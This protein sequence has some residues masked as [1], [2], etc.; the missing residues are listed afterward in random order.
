MGAEFLPDL[1]VIVGIGVV[2][3]L[4]LRKAGLPSI[5]GFIF[6]GALVGPNALGFVKDAHRV[7][8]VAELG[9]VLLLFGVGLELSFDRVRR[10]WRA[11]AFGGTLQV[12][13]TI[14]LAAGLARLGGVEMRPALF[15]GCFAAASSTA[16]VLRGLAARGEID[17]PYGRLTVGILIFQD[18]CV[19]PMML[20]LPVF[21]GAEASFWAVLKPI[22]VAALVLA[23]ILV[24]ARLV[25]PRILEV[26]ARTRQRDLFVLAVLL[27]CLGTA[28]ATTSA[29]LSLALGAF[30]GGLVVA[31]SEY[32]HQAL[33]DVIP[34]RELFASLFFV[35]VGMLLDPHR[36][37]ARPDA[38]LL[39]LVA[40][41]VGKFLAVLETAILLRLG[42]RT[43]VRSGAALAHVGEFSFVLAREAK[44]TGILAGD[45]GADLLSASALSML[46]A[47]LLMAA[48][49]R[50]AAGAGRIRWL[51]RLLEVRPAADASAAEK[52]ESH[53][54][55]AGYG[56]AGEE[57]CQALKTCGVPY[58]IVD[59]NP[60]NVHRAASRGEPAFF[61]DV[62]GPEILEA[63]GAHR[64]R[65]LVVLINDPTAAERAVKAA[66][67]LAPSLHIVVRS[68]YVG[69]IAPLLAAGASHVVPAELEAAVEVVAQVLARHGAG[70]SRLGAE[71]ARI[72]GRREEN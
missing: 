1:L 47:P 46:F 21:A 16:I 42:L 20:L 54:I 67:T 49:P 12:G 17:S 50:L 28:W 19:I 58:V 14:L 72:R 15:L 13:L 2:V 51:T 35:S 29:G 53:V 24:A 8:A 32:R 55:V 7:E 43:A 39:L 6:A 33:S 60:Q 56:V 36:L 65:E 11:V 62:T 71:I 18:L 48:G 66:R 9:V 45:L 4:L 63:V 59:L 30:L 31:G 10:L 34:F 37:L 41:L 25:V 26:V 69:D 23:G 44:G 61:G 64:A 70:A 22:G 57:L 52:C 3:V 38:V 40:I 5:A 68:R 27:V